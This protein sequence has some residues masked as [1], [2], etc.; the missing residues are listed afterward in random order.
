MAGA[1][2]HASRRIQSSHWPS[3]PSVLPSSL[4][5]LF[6]WIMF[7]RWGVAEDGWIQIGF[8]S[9]VMT[10]TVRCSRD[11]SLECQVMRRPS[12]MSAGWQE[13]R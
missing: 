2:I 11:T 1:S 3:N 9:P 13:I 7:G 5:Y 8:E 6:I 12:G 10:A 4:L